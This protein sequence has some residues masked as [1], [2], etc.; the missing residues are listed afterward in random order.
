M[1]WLGQNFTRH[2]PWA[3]MARGWT[4]YLARTSWLMRQGQHAADVAY[5]IGEEAPSPHCMATST[6]MPSPPV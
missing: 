5:F 1:P 4:D 2:E 3:E 6:S